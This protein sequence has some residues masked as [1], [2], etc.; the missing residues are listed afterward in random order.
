M[1]C[2]FRYKHAHWWHWL[3][4]KRRRALRQMNAFAAWYWERGG[5]TMLQSRIGDALLY[6][7]GYC[8][9]HWNPEREEE[10][11]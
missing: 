3:S 4:P 11:L 1:T 5:A 10:V 9:L 2:P 6:G 7:N 8:A